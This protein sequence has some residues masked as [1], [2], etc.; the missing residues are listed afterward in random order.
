MNLR[1]D[2]PEA[3]RIGAGWVTQADVDATRYQATIK[4][5]LDRVLAA[6]L[7]V[8]TMPLWLLIAIAITLDSP[9]PAIFVQQRLGLNGRPF[10]FYKFR[11][12]Y[13]DAEQRLHEVGPLNE[14]DGPVFKM[15][16][17]P[18]VTRFG[19]ALRRT[20]LDEL[21]Q[22]I[23]VLLGDMSLVGPRPPLPGEVERYRPGDGMRLLVKPGLTCLW[24][25]RGRSD[26]SFDQWMAYDREYI[27]RV[28]LRLDL[29]ILLRTVLVVLSH[30]GAY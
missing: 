21:P 20:S 5:I 8:A 19:R 18:R 26:C 30:H 6:L 23:N 25:I 2:A 16:N 4:P 27:E 1:V 22:L 29:S 28:S 13:V 12:M 17:D 9:G 24:Q 3:F 11:S 10:R 14:M 7:L 15:R